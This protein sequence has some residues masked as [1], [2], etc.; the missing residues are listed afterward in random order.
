MFEVVAKN[1]LNLDEY[2]CHRHGTCYS[3]T[4]FITNQMYA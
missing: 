3:S 4:K 1:D 2:S